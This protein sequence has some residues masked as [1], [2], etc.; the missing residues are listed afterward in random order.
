MLAALPLAVAVGVLAVPLTRSFAL[1]GYAAATI[2]AVGLFMLGFDVKVLTGILRDRPPQPLPAI[3]LPPVPSD[4]GEAFTLRYPAGWRERLLTFAIGLL[5]AGNAYPLFHAYVDFGPALG[6]GGIDPLY[7][8]HL[9]T[10]SVAM[11]ALVGICVCGIAAFARRAVVSADDAVLRWREGK[12]HLSLPWDRI[13]VLVAHISFGK[14][15]SF[16]A[17]AS[18][19]NHTT[20]RWPAGSRWV[21]A[22]GGPA[23]GDAAAEMA[24]LVAQRTGVSLTIVRH[25]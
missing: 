5:L 21:A 19:A 22:R 13:V 3:T 6:S 23:T 25:V 2:G 1:N 18:N 8:H 9:V 4:L 7:L 10:G 24:A 16:E 11:T 15:R 20:I 14:V 12:R 17:I